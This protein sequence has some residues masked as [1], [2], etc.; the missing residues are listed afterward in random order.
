MRREINKA[1]HKILYSIV[2]DAFSIV[3]NIIISIPRIR[4]YEQL[5]TLNA[6]KTVYQNGCAEFLN[7]NSYVY[8][9]INVNKGFRV[10][11]KRI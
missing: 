5:I 9:Y 2:S 1:N 3:V 8:V 11:H 6:A 4:H 7:H 10:N